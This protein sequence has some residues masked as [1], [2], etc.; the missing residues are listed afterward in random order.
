M[1]RAYEENL[2]E[3][4]PKLVPKVLDQSC[5]NTTWPLLLVV[6]DTN[7]AERDAPCYPSSSSPDN[8]KNSQTCRATVSGVLCAIKLSCVSTWGVLTHD[9]LELQTCVEKDDDDDDAVNHGC[10]GGVAGGA[11]GA[12]G[13]GDDGRRRR[14]GNQKTK[15]RI[16]RRT[17]S[18]RPSPR[19]TSSSRVPKD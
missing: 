3:A 11:G 9:S 5:A 7:V 8:K 10:S 19:V 16:A 15:N 12:G 14:R 18:H 17:A 4:G 13:G 2:F 1:S 6:F